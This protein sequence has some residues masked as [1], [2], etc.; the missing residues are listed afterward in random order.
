MHKLNYDKTLDKIDDILASWAHRNLTPIGK[1]TVLNSLI[2][3]LLVHKLSALPLPTKQFFDRYKKRIT[4]FL[5]N[6]KPAKIVYSKLIQNYD[7]LGLKLVDL[8]IKDVALKNAWPCRWNERNDQWIYNSLPMEDNRIWECNIS[9][10]DIDRFYQKKLS[11]VNS[12]WKARAKVNYAAFYENAEEILDAMI[13]GNSQ[14]RRKGKPIFDKILV[15]SNVEKILNVYNI[16]SN[17]YCYWFEIQEN[18]GVS[19]DQLYYW[20]IIAAFPNVWKVIIKNYDFKVPLDRLNRVENWIGKTRN[21]TVS[22][23]VYWYLIQERSIPPIAMKKV[24]TTTL[25]RFNR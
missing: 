20:G 11:T 17:K 25:K 10:E 3:S 15:T 24:W 14:I 8:E 13:I 12:I 22:K 18:Y 21:A 23:A 4:E 6:S 1:V 5:W 7:R 9:M 2:S 19:F 16:E